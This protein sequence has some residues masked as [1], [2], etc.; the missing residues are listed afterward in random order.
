M[1][2]TNLGL[3]YMNGE[4]GLHRNPDK[5]VEYYRR[6]AERGYAQA[7]NNLGMAYSSGIGNSGVKDSTLAVEWYRRAAEGKSSDAENNMGLAYWTGNGVGAKDP[8]KAVA[9][10]TRSAQNGNVQAQC[11]LGVALM[12]SHIIFAPICSLSSSMTCVDEQRLYFE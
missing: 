4:A 7:Q 8:N 5:A 11:S 12:V 2:M 3:C 9:F 6:A 10:W 1:A